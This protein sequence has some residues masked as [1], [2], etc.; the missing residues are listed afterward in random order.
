MPLDSKPHSK[1]L[2]VCHLNSRPLSN[3]SANAPLQRQL[4]LDYFGLVFH[5]VQRETQ[6]AGET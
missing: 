6:V 2:A 3:L 4:G 5:A 1:V